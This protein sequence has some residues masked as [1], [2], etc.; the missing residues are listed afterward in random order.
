MIHEFI[1]Q[2]MP[3]RIALSF[4]IVSLA[5]NCLVSSLRPSEDGST[6]LAPPGSGL[7]FLS[8]RVNGHHLRQQRWRPSGV[9]S[10]L[11]QVTHFA[12][13]VEFFCKLSEPGPHRSSRLIKA[14]L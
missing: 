3:G 14:M 5:L 4:S 1:Y 2:I 6:S 11:E 12:V 7:G 10:S 8:H 13:F 9:E